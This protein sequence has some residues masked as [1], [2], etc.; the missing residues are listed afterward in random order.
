MRDGCRVSRRVRSDGVPVHHPANRREGLK[1]YGYPGEI[2]SLGFESSADC[3]EP[4]PLERFDR[5][6]GF[7]E[8]IGDLRDRQ[9]AHNPENEN[10]ALVG[11]ERA[12]DLLDPVVAEVVDSLS[13]RVPAEELDDVRVEQ[14]RARPP[15]GRPSFVDEAALRDREDPSPKAGLI[16]LK[17]IHLREGANEDF[18]R[19]PVGVPGR[20]GAEIPHERRSDH[21][22]QPVEARGQAR[23]RGSQR[24]REVMHRG[25]GSHGSAYRP[26]TH[27]PEH[28]AGR[29]GRNSPRPPALILAMEAQVPCLFM[30]PAH[31]SQE[32]YTRLKDELAERSTTGRRDISM[33]IERAREHGDIKENADYDAAKNEQGHNESRIRQLEEILRTAVV[34]EGPAGDV[35]AP[36]TIVEVLVEGD[37]SPTAYLVGSIE[38][39]HDTLDVLSTSSPLG[40]ALLGHAPGET[41]S[42]QGPRRAFAVEIVSVRPV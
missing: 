31:L 40:Q 11:L 36:G 32:A 29:S 18:V 26:A 42:Y 19:E 3:G 33:W 41:V 34:V 1:G 16:P 25:P 13:F 38:E 39:R 30:E 8:R 15:R 20:L 2:W 27:V 21:A 17:L 28:P 7:V 10:I 22:K 37:E 35:V 12:Q 9:V 23:A 4:T 5:A 6:E 14:R 24:G